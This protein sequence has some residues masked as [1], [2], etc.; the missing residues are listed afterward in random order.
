LNVAAKS[1]LLSGTAAGVASTL[2]L[3][4]LARLEGKGILQPV[5]STSHRLNGEAA[6]SFRGADMTHTAVGLATR[7]AATFFWAA[8]FEASIA[9]GRPPGHHRWS[10]GAGVRQN[11]RGVGAAAKSDAQAAA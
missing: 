2:A 6:A 4:L 5:N 8:L 1:T 3:G 11:H 10:E 7:Q 9:G